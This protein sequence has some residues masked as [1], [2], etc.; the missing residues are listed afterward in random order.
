MDKI[1]DIVV[2]KIYISEQK[3]ELYSGI[4]NRIEKFH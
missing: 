2:L 4:T 3:C 1:E